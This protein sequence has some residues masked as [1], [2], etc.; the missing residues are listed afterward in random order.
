MGV[1]E[2]EATYVSSVET[3]DD[4]AALLDFLWHVGGCRLSS[5]VVVIRLFVK[6][7]VL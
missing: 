2:K 5:I 6:A 1:E 7:V 4:T 3:T